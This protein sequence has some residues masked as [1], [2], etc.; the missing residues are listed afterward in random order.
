MPRVVFDT[1]VF[2]RGLINPHSICGRLVFAQAD[3]YELVLSR[4]V[5]EE[6]VEVLHRPELTTRFRALAGIDLRALLELLSQAELVELETIA[7]VSRDR[8]DDK[9]LATAQAAAADYLVSEDQDLLVLVQHG[10]TKILS[11]SAFLA[12]LEQEQE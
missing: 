10:L 4:P 12:F 6:I 8:K 5:V 3:R 9:F 11:A 7:H 2:V 1:V